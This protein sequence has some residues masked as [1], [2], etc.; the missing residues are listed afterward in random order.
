MKLT[1]DAA[2]ATIA[3]VDLGEPERGYFDGAD[4]GHTGGNLYLNIDGKEYGSLFF[5]ADDDG[6]VV[7]TLGAF[8]PRTQD[9][10]DKNPL[11][12]PIPFEEPQT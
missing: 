2:G 4:L 10:Q 12:G 1:L 11:K 5:F 3:T 9:W 7:I 6:T 8:V